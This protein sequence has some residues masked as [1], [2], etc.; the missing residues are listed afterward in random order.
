MAVS[1][2]IDRLPLFRAN[3][4]RKIQIRNKSDQSDSSGGE[5]CVHADVAASE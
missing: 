4:T 2:P 1:V 5:R 3:V